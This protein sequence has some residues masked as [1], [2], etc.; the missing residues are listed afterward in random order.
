MLDEFE[1]ELEGHKGQRGRISKSWGVS[2]RHRNLSPRKTEVRLCQ[3]KLAC[4]GRSVKSNVL[5]QLNDVGLPEYL[6][7]FC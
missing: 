1:R 4:H 7:D 6:Q 2:K 5:D 3:A